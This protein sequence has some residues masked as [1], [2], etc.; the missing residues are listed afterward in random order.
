MKTVGYASRTKTFGGAGRN[1]FIWCVERTLLRLFQ[2]FSF[3]SFVLFVVNR[4]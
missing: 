3:V 1:E 4:F 2:D